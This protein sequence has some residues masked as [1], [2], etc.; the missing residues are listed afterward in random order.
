MV[1][2]EEETFREFGY[3]PSELKPQSNRRIFTACDDCGKVR[4]TSK[5]GYSALCK[6]CARK[7]GN[8]HNFEKHCSEETKKKIGAANKGR[9]QSE[10]TRRKISEAAKG[11]PHVS[12][13]GKKRISEAN[14]GK[15][16]SEETKQKMREARKHRVF[17][18]HHT[19]PELIFEDVCKR[20]NL[21]FKYT[22]DSSFWV[23][24][25]KDVINP[26]FIHLT[27]KVVVEVFSWFHDEMR[28]QHVQ[29]KSRYDDRKKIYKKY[30]YKM[31]VFWQDDLD[32][33]DAEARILS[34]LKK[35]KI[36]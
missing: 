32:R 31:I 15:H 17:P 25:G 6:S 29:P 34:V 28:N 10:E 14:K 36:I 22:G 12:E 9:K 8:N 11:K 27:R 1:I 16:P 19:K 18:K 7:G 33:E 13:E 23:G 24:R 20:N 4:I 3:Y 2:L 21:P 5:N 35:H 26:D 30:G